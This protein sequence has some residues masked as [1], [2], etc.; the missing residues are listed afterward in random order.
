MLIYPFSEALQ[1]IQEYQGR[2]AAFAAVWGFC[3]VLEL[4]RRAKQEVLAK[5]IQS[6][7]RRFKEK[8]TWN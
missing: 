6:I 3:G 7:I 5:R 1:K 4:E 2:R 8:D